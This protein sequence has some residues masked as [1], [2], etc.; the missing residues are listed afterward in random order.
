VS[1]QLRRIERAGS[2]R[3]QFYAVRDVVAVES[4]AASPADRAGFNEEADWTTRAHPSLRTQHDGAGMHG[5][6]LFPR[7]IVLLFFDDSGKFWV[8]DAWRDGEWLTQNLADPLVTIIGSEMTFR[9]P[10]L[11]PKLMFQLEFPGRALFDVL[12]EYRIRIASVE[13]FVSEASGWH[14]PV[15][16]YEDS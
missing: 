14:M 15:A 10:F 11:T 9:D 6:W 5:G 4:P 13:Q 2:T 1:D 12:D 7:A 3:P 8:E 16:I